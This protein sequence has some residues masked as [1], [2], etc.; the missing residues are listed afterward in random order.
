M[1]RLRGLVHHRWQMADTNPA[2]HLVTIRRSLEE[3][4]ENIA[5]VR[6]ELDSLPVAEDV[7][8]SIR[9]VC[10]EFDS[11][12][13]DVRKEVWDLA[14]ML[15]PATGTAGGD[16]RA[17][18]S[19]IRSWL[20]REL[21]RLHALVI[22]LQSEP[23]LIPAHILVAESATNIY[24]AFSRIE[25][26]LDSLAGTSGERGEKERREAVARPALAILGFALVLAALLVIIVSDLRKGPVEP[27]TGAALL[28]FLVGVGLSWIARRAT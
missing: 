10:E 18:A 19:L 13:Y 27:Q 8:A 15:D 17:T 21:E 1:A 24:R 16:P 9:T 23:A 28:L 11:A 4:A 26:A 2:Q 6:G 25:T 3:M 20:R 7:R 5:F 14:D 12:L 22:S